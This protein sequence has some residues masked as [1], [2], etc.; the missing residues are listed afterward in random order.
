MAEPLEEVRRGQG[1]GAGVAPGRCLPAAPVRCAPRARS[2]LP[3]WPNEDKKSYD[4]RLSVAVC[5][6][7]SAHGHDAGRQAVQ[8]PADPQRGH[9]GADQGLAR[10][11]RPAGPQ[12]ARLRRRHDGAR[13]GVGLFGILVEYPK[14]QDVP[15]NADGVRTQAAEPLQACG[16][17]SWRSRP[18]R[19]SAG[20]PRSRAA[21]V[22]SSRSCAFMECVTEP[23]GEFGD[24]EIEQVRVLE[25][26]HVGDLAQEGR[27]P[28]RQGRLGQ[29]RRAR[30]DHARLHPLRAR[31]M[32]SARA[33]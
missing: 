12:P 9:A 21:N 17:T 4:A 33:S 15:T 3:Q 30:R 28:D 18:S 13:A 32:A 10:R 25:P 7:R 20:A 6:R 11:C 5:T 16:R 14:A 29:A 27:Q 26:G 24:V 8:Q 19:C 23:A 2:Y 1:D 22:V 31:S